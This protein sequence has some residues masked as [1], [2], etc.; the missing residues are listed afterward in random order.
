MPRMTATVE[1]GKVNR[2]M[3]SQSM[4]GQRMMRSIRKSLSHPFAI[5]VLKTSRVTNSDV[6]MLVVI[7]RPR[8]SAK[9]FTSW[10][11]TKPRTTQ[12]IKVVRL[13]SRMVE[14]ALSYPA[15]SAFLKGMPRSRSSRI[16]SKISTL[17]SIAIPTVRISPAIPGSV[18]VACIRAMM[19]STNSKFI[20]RATLVIPP[21][22]MP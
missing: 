17:A 1:T 16:R 10:L 21:A 9:P 4:E 22:A 12:V 3:A 20:A 7:P 13:A 15:L 11:P 2:R 6:N 14:K 19:L 18:K 8:T 5:S